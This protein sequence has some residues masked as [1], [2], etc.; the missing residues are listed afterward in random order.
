[1]KFWVGVTDKAWY[2]HLRVLTPDEVNFWQPTPRRLAEFLEAGVPFLFKLHAPDNYVVGG[3]FFVRF[4]ALPARLA[5]EA[6]EE[7][8]GVTDYG[9]LRK[10]IE[11]YR[12][13]TKGDPNRLQCAERPGFLRGEELDRGARELGAEH[14]SRPHL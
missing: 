5:W 12:G 3:G 4:S 2:E 9:A 13:A 6:F 8:N 7:K 1:M 14:R 11:Q 10:R